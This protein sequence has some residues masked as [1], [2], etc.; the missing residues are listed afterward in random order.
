VQ[1]GATNHLVVDGPQQMKKP[2]Q[3]VVIVSHF[4]FLPQ[5]DSLI[6]NTPEQDAPPPKYLCPK[7]RVEQTPLTQ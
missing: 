5:K 3:S 1:D 6:L 7:E 4:S 2:L